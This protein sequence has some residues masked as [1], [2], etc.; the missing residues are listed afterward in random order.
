MPIL[1]FTGNLGLKFFVDS[2][3]NYD[4][5]SAKALITEAEGNRMIA[6]NHMPAAAYMEKMGII[7][8][9]KLDMLFAFPLAIDSGHGGPPQL[10]IIYAIN[11]DGSLTCSANIPAGS[12][13]CIDSPGSGEVL[14]TAKNVTD[15][16][17]RSGGEA[18][19]IFSC[20]GRSVIQTNPHD[21]MEMVQ[22]ELKN[23]ALPY[24]LIYSGGEICPAYGKNNA[25]LN[26][27]HNYVIISCLLGA[28][29]DGEK[30]SLKNDKNSYR[31]YL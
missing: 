21:E 18:L 6:V 24:L 8:E 4:I 31:P 10:C 13:L 12:T 19:L 15:A 30:G 17:K 5:H 26:E 28:D 7:T 2:V 29:Q 22:E 14:T 1:L 23:T 11:G 3:W 20:F 9:K 16:A 27:Y 25:I